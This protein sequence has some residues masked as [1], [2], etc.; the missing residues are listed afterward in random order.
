MG[1]WQQLEERAATGRAARVAIVGTGYVGSSLLHRLRRTPGIDPV[2]VVN[3]T[4]D[5]GRAAWAGAGVDTSA[6]CVSDDPTTLSDA[7]DRGLPALSTTVDAVTLEQLD[8]V[9]NVT[10]AIEHGAT[11]D[12]RRIGGRDD[13][14]CR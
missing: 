3:R 2:L 10:G 6:L 4:V 9:V 12:A 5:R 11:R 13:T 8:V 14:W 7:I 1:V